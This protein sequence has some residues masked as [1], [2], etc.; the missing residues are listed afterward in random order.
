[1]QERAYILAVQPDGFFSTAQA[2]EPAP[3]SRAGG[4]R[5]PPGPAFRHDPTGTIFLTL[6]R[7]LVRYLVHLFSFPSVQTKR[8]L[9]ALCGLLLGTLPGT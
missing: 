8:A 4:Q 6:F 1:M 2:V 3:K 5:T 7:S 9:P